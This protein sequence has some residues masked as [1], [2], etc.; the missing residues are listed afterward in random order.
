MRLAFKPLAI[1]LLALLVAAPTS[2]VAAKQQKT[3][4][5]IVI[6]AVARLEQFPT[7]PP[8]FE[9]DF[10]ASGAIKDSGLVGGGRD[11]EGRNY[12]LLLGKH[13]T[14]VVFITDWDP[15]MGTFEIWQPTDGAWPGQFLGSGTATFEETIKGWWIRYR[16]QLDGTLVSS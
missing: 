9:V 13:A 1:A 8:S 10:R 4:F 12:T 11:G 16:W 15:E 14:Y 6:R 7:L 5:S 3:A 2:A